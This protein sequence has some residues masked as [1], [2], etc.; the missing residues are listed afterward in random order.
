MKLYEIT[1]QYREALRLFEDMSEEISAQTIEATMESIEHEFHEKC[2]QVAM[3]IKTQE[4]DAAAIKEAEKE[5]AERRKRLEKSIDWLK[6]YLIINMT[7]TDNRIIKCP[8]FDIRTVATAGSIE[9]I[10]MEQI[11]AQYIDIKVVESVKLQE[12]KNDINKGIFVPGAQKIPGL[13]LRIK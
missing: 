12:I 9:V 1:D 4:A 11:P 3:M 6:E 5:M 13:S 8:Y 2:V 10:D 7:T